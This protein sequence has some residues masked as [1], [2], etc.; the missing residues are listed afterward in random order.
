MY[1][2]HTR[3]DAASQRHSIGLYSLVTQRL[4]ACTAGYV[5]EAGPGTLGAIPI[6]SGSRIGT[7]VALAS[8]ENVQATST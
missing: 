4:G 6:V 8:T 1:V 2:A 5:W 3:H 7:R